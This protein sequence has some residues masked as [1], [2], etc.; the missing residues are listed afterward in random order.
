MVDQAR[1]HKPEKSKLVAELLKRHG[2]RVKLRYLPSYS[3]DCMPMELFW[4][5]WRDHVTHNHARNKL[6][7]LMCDSDPSQA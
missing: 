5:D 6:D 7:A 1:I 3:P 2:R 4:N